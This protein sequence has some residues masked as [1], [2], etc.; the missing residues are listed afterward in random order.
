M[1]SEIT[2]RER[3]WITSEEYTIF[4]LR[5][6]STTVCCASWPAASRWG[7]SPCSWPCPCTFR[8]LG[9]EDID[10]QEGSTSLLLLLQSWW[11]RWRKRPLLLQ[12]L[13]SQLASQ[14]ASPNYALSLADSLTH[15]L[16]LVFNTERKWKENKT[17]NDNDDKQLTEVAIVV[18]TTC[19]SLFVVI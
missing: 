15:S 17:E 6:C 11:W 8:K 12:R 18:A 19:T 5:G 14:S 10:R 2:K 9:R 1:T 7:Q 4:V 13:L 16:T 3:K